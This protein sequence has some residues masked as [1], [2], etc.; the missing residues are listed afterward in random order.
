MH[1]SS[2]KTFQL[3]LAAV[4]LLSGS[5]T[6]AQDNAAVVTSDGNAA[7]VDNGSDMVD[8]G[9]DHDHEY[10]SDIETLSAE[11]EACSKA[12][13]CTEC[14]IGD[15]GKK[16]SSYR[17]EHCAEIDCCPACDSVIRGMWACEHGWFCGEDLGTCDAMASGA[18]VHKGV[19]SSLAAA[20]VAATILWPVL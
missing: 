19:G 6:L 8:H 3:V 20:G 7:A 17:M 11:E 12:N 15:F 5:P 18:A 9:H 14:D 10:C 4:A 2:Q 13:N 1:V 16:C